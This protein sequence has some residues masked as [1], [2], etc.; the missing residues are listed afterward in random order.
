MYPYY[1]L[2]Q[3]KL[4]VYT[5]IKLWKMFY[6]ADSRRL[7]HVGYHDAHGD[8]LLGAPSV[9]DGRKRGQG[10]DGIAG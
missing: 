7:V 5:T 3:R 9:E 2:S 8:A 10:C 1:S 6:I 4:H